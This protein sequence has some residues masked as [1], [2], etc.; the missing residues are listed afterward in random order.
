VRAKKPRSADYNQDRVPLVE[1]REAVGHGVCAGYTYA[2]MTDIAALCD[3][4]EY[5]QALDRLW[6]DVVGRK[7]YL[8]GSGA[9]AQY[10]DE[11]FGDPYHLPNHTA[12]C[13]TC[14]SVAMVLWSHRMALLHADAAYAD[15]LERAIY[16]GVL[17]G[18][19]LSGDHYFYKNPLASRGDFRRPDSWNPACCQSNLVRIIPQVGAMAYATSAD[20]AFVNLFV[21]GT[22][23]L[24][25]DSG[26][27][28]LAVETDYPHDG[29]IRITVV[30][31]P[32]QPFTMALRIPGWARERPI[33]SDLY[34]FAA[35]T[36]QDP[37]L[38]IS[39]GPPV[40]VEPANGY[41][42]LER[43]WQPGDSIELDLPMPVRRVLAHDRV[44]ANEGRVALQRG[45]LVY[46]LEAVDHA[47]LRTDA[48]VLPD[49][50]PLEAGRRR[51]LP[52]DAVVVQ[53]DASIA[54]EPR[55]GEETKTR[56]QPLV[57]VPYYAWANRGE[58]YM[59]VW[60]ARTPDRATPLPAATAVREA[61]ITASGQ[62][63]GSLAAIHDGRHGPRSAARETPR[64]ALT[65]TSDGKSWIQCQWPEPRELSR[66]A[67]YFAVDRRS[68]VYWGPRIRG[69]DLA[70]PKSWRIL[71]QDGD[72]W[73]PVEPMDPYTLRLDLPNEARFAPVKTRALR[74][75]VECAEAPCAV[76]EW[77]IE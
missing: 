66:T 14:S 26:P 40:P 1:A 29:R 55:W 25:L 44:A 37:T 51:D 75:E 49:E 39:G 34:R 56:P 4:T 23:T 24:E 65:G 8:I 69:V 47:G 71:Y 32:D 35:P 46:C 59:D 7:L 9:T 64:V 60:L 10:H 53:A 6:K 22:A 20:T 77:W 16:N 52:G 57:A 72:T 27:V 68:Q 13:E 43:I 74:L 45:P 63:R 15:V 11:G 73:Q 62:T 58:G 50:V 67:V 76:Q 19:S 30:S 54:F 28:E 5:A 41:A 33:P 70:V 42:R 48:I 61:K 31:G 2:A 17:S 3:D 36:G 12:Y 38:T 21:S 18:L